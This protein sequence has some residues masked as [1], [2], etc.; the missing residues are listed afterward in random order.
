MALVLDLFPGSAERR[1]QRAGTMSGGEQQMLAVGRALMAQPE[2]AD[3]RRT[4]DRARAE[5]RRRG[6]RRAGTLREHGLTIVVAEQQ[7]PWRSASP[8]RA[9]CSRTAASSSEGRRRARATPTSSG[10]PGDRLR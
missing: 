10:L 9:T 7:V 6:L 2:V 8:S 1:R 3:A 5:A 4:D